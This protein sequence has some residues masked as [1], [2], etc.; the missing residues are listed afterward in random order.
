MVVISPGKDGIL[1][2]P[3]AAEDDLQRRTLTMA[4]PQDLRGS[5]LDAVEE[6]LFAP[7]DE[8]E[9]RMREAI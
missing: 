8:P 3:P 4:I 9:L 2:R 5:R 6:L 7:T 1:S